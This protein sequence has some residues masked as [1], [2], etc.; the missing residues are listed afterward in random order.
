MVCAFLTSLSRSHAPIRKF[1]LLP[2]TSLRCSTTWRDERTEQRESALKTR[3]AGTTGAGGNKFMI[4][5]IPCMHRGQ[6]LYRRWQ[7]TSRRLQRVA[8]VRRIACMGTV[9]LF[10]AKAGMK[11]SRAR[12]RMETPPQREGKKYGFFSPAPSARASAETA[13]TTDA[14]V[15]ELPMASCLPQTQATTHTIEQLLCILRTPG[16]RILYFV[17]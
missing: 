14:R 10:F 6:C 8:L 15:P 12:Q 1:V 13:Q 7:A 3:N 5:Q 9:R 4:S 2:K 17:S 11:P 16:A